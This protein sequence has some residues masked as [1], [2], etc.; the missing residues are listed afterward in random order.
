MEEAIDRREAVNLWPHQSR[1]IAEVH[2]A[3]AEGKRKIVLTSPTGGGKSKMVGTLLGDYLAAG[4]KAVLYTNKKM[5]TTQNADVL[6]GMGL[7][8][9]LR[10]AGHDTDY[11]QLLQIASMQT[12]HSRTER[13][14]TRLLHN[15]ELVI[16]EEAHVQMGKT[17]LAILQKHHDEGA[18]I[19]GITATPLDMG[20]FYDHLIVAGTNS[21]LRACG[22][23][24]SA[25]HFGADEPDLKAMKIKE[26][27]GNN[28]SE[29]QQKKAIMTKTIFA[30]V[31]QWYD[32]LNPEQKPSI[33]FGPGVEESLWFAERFTEKGIPAA[34]IDGSDVWMHGKFY[35]ADDEAR[36]A[37]ADASKDGSIKVVCNRF[38]LREGVNWPWI[39]HMILAYVVG[40]L[41]TYL[42]VGGRGLR[43]NP[44]TGK[45]HL[46][47]Q[48]HGGAWW[49]F[50]SLNADRVWDLRFTNTMI[51]GLRADRLR[52]K[53]EREP[54]R[55][56]CGRIMAGGKACECGRE[57]PP[58]KSRPVVMEDG[59]MRE[60]NGDIFRPRRIYGGNDGRSRWEKMYWR[61]RNGKGIRT[62]RAA[63]ALFSHENNWGWPDP[64]WPYMPIH[65]LDFYQLV[66]DVPQERLR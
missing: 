37:V 66:P 5:L 46:T 50:G 1:G 30:R 11:K 62:F 28:L 41:Q 49:K 54:W 42:Q 4:K 35:K 27:D 40:N 17:V 19:V 55:C 51:A 31:G 33:L 29:K 34:H 39:E 32:K 15:A 3:I 65:E 20:D 59:S 56:P 60:L 16:V 36:K 24:V 58:K 64:T 53:K 44:S 13:S 12:E 6:A 22:A 10:A 47:V 25:V 61:S 52:Q 63:M 57:I 18:A 43:A 8:Y 48:D 2:A 45:T 14:K 21:E 7:E 26:T 38:V 9:G 23:L